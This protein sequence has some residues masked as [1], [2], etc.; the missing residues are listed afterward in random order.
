MTPTPT[1]VN[2]SFTI[3]GDFNKHHALWSGPLHHT[4]TAN[5]DTSLLINTMTAHRLTQCIK[6]GTPPT[7]PQ[8]TTQ[9]RP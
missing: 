6:A 3:L 4:H 2:H 1:N 9:H 5:S 8:S 7:N